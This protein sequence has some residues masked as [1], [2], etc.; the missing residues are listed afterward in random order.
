M[1]F[2]IPIIALFYLIDLWT[3]NGQVSDFNARR[4]L[5]LAAA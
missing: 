3:L 5:A 4:P 1:F 2:F